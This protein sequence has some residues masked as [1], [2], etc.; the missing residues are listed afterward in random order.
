MEAF[1]DYRN[2]DY[3]GALNSFPQ[4][5]RIPSL[6]L[7]LFHARLVMGEIRAPPGG[8]AARDFG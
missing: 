3:Q 8:N 2:H 4:L 7:F 1:K 5:A 6:F